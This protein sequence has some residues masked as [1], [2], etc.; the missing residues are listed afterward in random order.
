[1]ENE[2]KRTYQTVKKDA[3]HYYDT[4]GINERDKE[5]PKGM[6]LTLEEAQKA[7]EEK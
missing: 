4:W 3:D 5:L 2:S 6:Y 7:L 1:M